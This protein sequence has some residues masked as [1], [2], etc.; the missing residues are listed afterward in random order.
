M[1]F[2]QLLDHS[3][4]SLLFCIIRNFVYYDNF[5]VI[6]CFFKTTKIC[7]IFIF[8]FASVFTFLI[9]TQDQRISDV[10]NP[11][12]AKLKQIS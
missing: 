8:N 7:V 1:F 3:L 6:Y 2:F 9:K 10:F 12:R 11:Y 5:Q 4:D